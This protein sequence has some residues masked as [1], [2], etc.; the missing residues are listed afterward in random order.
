MKSSNLLKQSKQF[1]LIDFLINK[2]K[3]YKDIILE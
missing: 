3:D 2:S 1:Q